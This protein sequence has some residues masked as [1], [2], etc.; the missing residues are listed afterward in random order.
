MMKAL[1]LS[2]AAVVACALPVLVS[3]QEAPAPAAA[4][5]EE[6]GQDGLAEIVVTAQRRSETAQRAALAIDVVTAESLQRTGVVTPTTLNAAVPSLYVTR[7]GGANTSFFIRGVGN[8]TNNAYSDPAV[9]FNVDGV[10]FGRPTSTTGTFYDLERLEVLKGPQGTLYGRNATAGAINVIPAKPLLNTFSGYASAGYG[11][12]DALDLEAV[13][14]VPLGSNAAFR[15][16]GKVFDTK[17]F[18][19]DGTGDEVG[20]AVRAQL[21]FEPTDNLTIRL[22]GDYSHT[23]GIGTGYSFA[24]N[25]L[26]TPGAAATASAPANYTFVPSGMDPLSGLHSPAAA[27]YFSNIVLGGPQIRPAPLNFPFQDNSYYGFHADVSLK[28]GIGTLTVIPAYRHSRIDNLFNGPAFRG[29]LIDETDKQFSLEARF[30]G[31]RIGPIEWLVGAFYYDE[32]ITGKYA[33]SQYTVQSYQQFQTGTQSYAFFGRATAHLT[34]RLRL[35]GG[36][37]YTNDTKPFDGGATNLVQIC[38]APPTTPVPRCAGGPSVPVAPSFAELAAFIPANLIPQGLPTL[39]GPANSRPFGSTGSRLFIIPIRINETLTASRVTYRLAAEFDVGPNS[40]LYASYETG[41]RSGGFNVSL[42]RETYA[43]EYIEALTIGSKNRFFDNRLQVNVEAF[44]WTY[45]D[46]QVQ[47]FGLDSTGNNSA[48]SENIGRSRIQG[49]DVDVQGK[50]TRTTTLRGSVQYLDN[51]LTSFS[52]DVAATTPPLVGC[53]FAP[54]TDRF[55][56]AAFRVNCSGKPGFNSPKWAANFGA[57]QLIELGDYKL[58][59]NADARYRG[60]RVI[61]F[62]YLPQQNST[63]DFSIDLAATFAE[64]DDRWSL[65]AWVR[66]VTDQRIPVIAQFAGS[67][68]NAITVGYAPPRTFGARLRYSF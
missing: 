19:Q 43:P 63:D 6:P 17:G 35:V 44:R 21:L 45:R 56:R 26:F 22:S 50:V 53:S 12:F 39:P 23:G 3:A 34:D 61:G 58:V 10:Y 68:G 11:R 31:D 27:Q 57:E 51:Q 28:T 24:G 13:I 8:F 49:V 65:S 46:Q 25:V 16:S 55:G 47:H 64:I 7:G 48:F 9:A 5:A 60:N 62:E 32:D 2:T 33:F 1:L 18:F 42:G 38:A 59:L 41:F 20:E 14:N 15:V 37:R 54:A 52:Y 67:T 29:G 40:L 4:V 30:D 36:L 66:N